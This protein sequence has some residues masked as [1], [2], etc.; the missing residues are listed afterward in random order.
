MENEKNNVE[1]KIKELIIK[2]TQPVPGLIKTKELNENVFI[3][4]LFK[5]FVITSPNLNS[6]MK[7]RAG[8]QAMLQKNL[9]DSIGM[10]HSKELSETSFL[11]DLFNNFT[12]TQK[13]E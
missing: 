2:S 6:M 3:N 8:I 1:T 13:T 10:Y 4:N 5:H 9:K 7:I 11:N 12:L